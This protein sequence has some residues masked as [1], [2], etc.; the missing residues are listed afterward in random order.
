MT[1]NH[2][3]A[4][5]DIFQVTAA[6]RDGLHIPMIAGKG[7]LIVHVFLDAWIGTEV[8]VNSGFRFFAAHIRLLA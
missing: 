1:T 4:A 6:A 8:P 5:L 3:I 2:S 7:H